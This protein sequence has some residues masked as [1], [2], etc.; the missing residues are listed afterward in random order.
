MTGYAALLRGIGPTNPNMRNE[1]LRSVFESLG[2]KKV[3][4][5]ISSGNILFES[6]ETNMNKLEKQIE[7]ATRDQ[8]G[9]TTVA[10]IRSR[11]ELQKVIS[12][13][14]FTDTAEHNQKTYLTVTFFKS[15]PKNLP[16][17]PFAPQGK[18]FELLGR[19]DDAIYSVVNLTTGTTPDLM[20]WLEKQLSKQI[21]TRT[22][23]TMHRLLKKL[24]EM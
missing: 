7:E 3:Q 23:K 24:D 12:H 17:F 14:P 15:S 16:A 20:T 18:S 22:L 2:L 9:F 8:L 19:C 4:T 6:D 11:D 21:T 1:K 5:V 10:I 13:H